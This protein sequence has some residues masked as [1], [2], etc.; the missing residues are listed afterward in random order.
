MPAGEA[1][2][3]RD[4][5]PAGWGVAHQE[6]IHTVADGRWTR[7]VGRLLDLLFPPR[8]A[9]CGDFGALLCA[10]CRRYLEPLGTERCPR[11]GRPGAAVSKGGWCGDCVDRDLRFATARSAF[12]Y[13]GAARRV[14]AA[15]KY[16][17]ERGLAEI[18]AEEAFPAFGG[19]VAELPSPVVT[20]VPSHSSTRSARGFN[21]AQLFARALVARSGGLRA[22]ELVRKIRAT[23]HQQALSRE[24]RCRNLARSFAAVGGPGSSRDPLAAAGSILVVDDVYTTGATASEVAGVVAARWGR[25]VHVFTF[26]RAMHQVSDFRD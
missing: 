5:G 21:Q 7:R 10:D 12:L 18:M 6:P 2:V 16:G 22:S 11:C 4:R 23:P 14:V 20:W 25:P 9:S 13:T 15:L 1:P 8:C 3:A 17:G 26:A 19:L 24:E